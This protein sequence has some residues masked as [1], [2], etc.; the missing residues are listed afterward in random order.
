M[1]F[2]Q[3]KS[4]FPS[5]PP[6]IL[7]EVK[8]FEQPGVEENFKVCWYGSAGGD[9]RVMDYFHPDHSL[10]GEPVTVFFFTDIAY[11]VHDERVAWNGNHDIHYGAA[12]LR[13]RSALKLEDGGEAPAMIYLI[14]NQRALRI[15]IQADDALFERLMIKRGLKIDVVSY[16]NGIH[17]GPGPRAL[18]GLRADFSFGEPRGRRPEW[19]EGIQ[20]TKH[21]F[22]FSVAKGFCLIPLSQRRMGPANDPREVEFC[23]VVRLPS[24]QPLGTSTPGLSA[25][26]T[27]HFKACSSDELQNAENWK[28]GQI[29]LCHL[30]HTLETAD[31]SGLEDIL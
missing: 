5:L 20:W 31:L 25:D 14:P 7:C 17:A 2:A 13:H 27:H 22:G 9:V 10:M 29:R 23:K 28:T 15:H 26:F 16:L 12:P 21:D 30:S 11:V 6:D 8:K 3:L 4:L 1:T 18:D 24:V 19:T